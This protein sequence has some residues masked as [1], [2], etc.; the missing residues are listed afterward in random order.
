MDAQTQ[1]IVK[2]IREQTEAIKGYGTGVIV[3]CGFISVAILLAAA[4]ISGKI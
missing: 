4:S 3:A 1:E 2:A